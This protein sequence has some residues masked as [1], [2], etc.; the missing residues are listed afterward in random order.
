MHPEKVCNVNK[1]NP[2]GKPNQ[3][4]SYVHPSVLN[5]SLTDSEYDQLKGWGLDMSGHAETCVGRYGQLT[6]VSANDFK[7][8]ATPCMDDHTFTSE[9][10]TEK[11]KLSEI[12]ARVVLKCLYLA[13]VGR[14]DLLWTVNLLARQVTKWTKA[15]DRRMERLI[16]YIHHNKDHTHVNFVGDPPEDCFLAL[17]Q[18]ASFVGDLMDS[19]STSGGLPALVGP[20]TFVTWTWR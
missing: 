10:L 1:G 14:P 7:K 19:K 18:D 13:S 11:G 16:S 8:V 2:K 6:G 3:E 15:C 20:K 5:P 17:F 4:C 9:E 12:S